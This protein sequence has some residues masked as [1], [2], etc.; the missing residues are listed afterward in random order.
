MSVPWVMTMP[1]TSPDAATSRT[2][3][4][5]A[6]SRAASK[7]HAGIRAQSSIRKGAIRSKPGAN[8]TSAAP[9]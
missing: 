7:W 8:P 9:P 2:R 3:S 4:R 1:V 6:H 5:R